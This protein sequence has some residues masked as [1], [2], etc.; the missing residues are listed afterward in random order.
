M[1]ADPA[2]V[3]PDQ[4]LGHP[5]H[6]ADRSPSRKGRFQA[7]STALSPCLTPLVRKNS[8]SPPA[9]PD[10]TPEQAFRNLEQMHFSRMTGAGTAIGAFVRRRRRCQPATRRASDPC[11]GGCSCPRGSTSG[12]SGRRK[13]WP[14]HRSPGSRPAPT[15][16]PRVRSGSSGPAQQSRRLHLERNTNAVHPYICPSAALPDTALKT[17]RYR[18]L[19]ARYGTNQ[20]SQL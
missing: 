7:P 14:G 1:P 4:P 19:T 5:P 17:R 11:M 20:Y 8:P 15:G 3:V 18:E 9:H 2:L 6:R 10:G 12:R 13:C 16:T